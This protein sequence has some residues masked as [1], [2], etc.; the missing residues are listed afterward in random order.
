MS[1]LQAL[2]ESINDGDFTAIQQMGAQGFF[3]SDSLHSLALPAA[4][5]LGEFGL[6]SHPTEEPWAY[7]IGVLAFTN[8]IHL[9]LP[10][11]TLDSWMTRTLQWP[12]AF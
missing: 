3:G 12:L 7:R 10:T 6:R 8:L 2:R 1:S 9:A 5:V 11:L 4:N